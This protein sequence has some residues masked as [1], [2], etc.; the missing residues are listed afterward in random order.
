MFCR[1]TKAVQLS[2]HS[3]SSHQ[4]QPKVQNGQIDAHVTVRLQSR[5]PGRI[6]L[7][8]IRAWRMGGLPFEMHRFN[9]DPRDSYLCEY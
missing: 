5:S 4:I 7:G 6:N 2:D 3:D 1:T 8:L 9:V